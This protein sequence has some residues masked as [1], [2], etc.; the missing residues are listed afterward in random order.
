M[1]EL[2]D[3]Y[4]SLLQAA[5]RWRAGRRL[6]FKVI[7]PSP[8]TPEEEKAMMIRRGFAKKFPLYWLSPCRPPGKGSKRND[9]GAYGGPYNC[10]WLSFTKEEIIDHILG[11]IILS[12]E[13]KKKCDQ[14]QDGFI[15]ICD[16]VLFLRQ[17]Y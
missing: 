14:N 12:E 13:K 9:M 10:G 3:D 15:D 1:E 6:S 17:Y 8:L 11:R 5:D 2:G 7:M 4:F 16:V